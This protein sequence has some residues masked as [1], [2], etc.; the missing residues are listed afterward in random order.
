MGAMR[1]RTRGKGPHLNLPH[2]LLL[3]SALLLAQGPTPAED[4]NASPPFTPTAGEAAWLAKHPK[5]RIGTM[6]AWPP[7]NYVDDRG[8]PQGIGVDYVRALNKRLGGALVIVPGPFKQNCESVKSKRLGA[9]MD[10]TPKPEREAFFN[11]TRPYVTIPQVFVGRK[12]EDSFQSEQD[13]FGK[14]VALE[15]GFEFG[16]P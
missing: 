10:I 5:I 11:F 13:L 14:S 9:L 3:L 8:T 1:S 15:R 6:N 12:G 7:M 2:T 16:Q 4:G